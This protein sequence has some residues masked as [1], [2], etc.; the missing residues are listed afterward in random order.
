[1]TALAMELMRDLPKNTVDWQPN[2]DQR[3]QEPLVLPA[4]LP[5]LLVNGAAGIAVGMATNLPP[6][7]LSEVIDAIIMMIDRPNATVAEL[8]QKLPGPDFPTA[9]LILGTRG[10]RE[11]Y[12]TGRGSVVMQAKTQIEPMDGGRHAIVV[13]E[14]P[15]QVNKRRLI[16]QIADLV[17]ARKIE[18]IS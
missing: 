16:E 14:L 3:Q 6:H 17:K 4:A 13:T 9:G 1:M 2:Y 15:Y 7:N 11:A 18:G 5:N 8:M 12:E 10:I